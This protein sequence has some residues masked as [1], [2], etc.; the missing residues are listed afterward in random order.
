MYSTNGRNFK[1]VNGGDGE[2]HSTQRITIRDVNPNTQYWFMVMAGNNFDYEEEGFIVQVK[3]LPRYEA[4]GILKNPSFDDGH[5]GWKADLETHYHIV[6]NHSHSGNFAGRLH[7]PTRG[8]NRKR[9][10][11]STIRQ[12]VRAEKSPGIIKWNS[13]T[14]Q[15]RIIIIAGWSKVERFYGGHLEWRMG[16]EVEFENSLTKFKYEEDFDSASSGWQVRTF[17]ICISPLAQVSAIRVMGQLIA[18]RGSV[19]FDDFTVLLK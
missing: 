17:S 7:I 14:K 11:W 1:T 19:F 9:P 15:G 10:T 2:A 5:F 8:Y 3:S 4:R 12:T 13:E 18:Y 6:A 16:V